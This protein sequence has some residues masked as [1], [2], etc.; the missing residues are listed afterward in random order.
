MWRGFQPSIGQQIVK[1]PGILQCFLCVEQHRQAS[2]VGL[3]LGSAWAPCILQH[4]VRGVG[5]NWARTGNRSICSKL[6]A[7]SWSL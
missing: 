2:L 1:I 3:Q 4:F 6:A 5:L 7:G